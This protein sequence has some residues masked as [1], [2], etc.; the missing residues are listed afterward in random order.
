M[1][2]TRFVDRVLRHAVSVFLI[3]TYPL[4]L[5]VQ[6]RPGV[7]KTFQTYQSL[8]G[9]GFEVLRES[10]ARLQGRHEGDSVAEFEAVYER[11][12]E[13]MEDPCRPMAAILIEDFD[14]SG[15]VRFDKTEYTV[16]QQLLV[17]Y[18][19]NLCD[20]IVEGG[21]QAIRIPIYLTGNNFST[22]HE[23]LRRHGRLDAFTWAPDKDELELVVAS[24][25]AGVASE[26]RVA[27]GRLLEAF[28]EASL[29]T[30]RFLIDH[31]ASVY[32]YKQ[33]AHD[34]NLG[35]NLLEH[36]SYRPFMDVP[37]D[38]LVSELAGAYAKLEEASNFLNAAEVGGAGGD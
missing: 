2:P 21:G 6:G 12:R 23:P 8:R 15:A 18:L 22:L 16:N 27:A 11:A 13:C 32:I 14:L 38:H 24:M 10:A 3:P 31:V 35:L 20:G 7:G 9:A 1:I 26:P 37:T 30:L 34:P 5:A 17:N 4:L 25:I 29:A 19:M 36:A 33:L 28:P